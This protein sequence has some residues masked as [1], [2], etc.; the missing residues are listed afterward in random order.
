MMFTAG[1]LL[2]PQV[3]IVPLY[4]LYLAAVPRPLSDNGKLLYDQFLGHHPDPHRVPDSASAS[5]S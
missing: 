5:S 3:I 2:P 4:R 1:N